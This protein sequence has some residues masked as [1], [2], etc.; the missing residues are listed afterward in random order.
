MKTDN[1]GL[2]TSL[3]Q[4]PDLEPQPLSWVVKPAPRAKSPAPLPSSGRLWAVL[5]LLV[6][7]G[8]HALALWIPFGQEQSLE[9][10]PDEEEAIALT[11]L[12]PS[13]PESAEAIPTPPP[14]APRATPPVPTARPQAP[15]PSRTIPAVASVTPVTNPVTPGR[16]E[17]AGA[18]PETDLFLTEFP[19][20]PG[21]KPGVLGL[22]DAYAAFSQNTEAALNPVAN[23]F[24]TELQAK[25]YTLQDLSEQAS[26]RVYLVS[27]GD[28]RQYLTLIS[29]PE[30]AGTNI[31]LS[32][33]EL[34]ED[35][36]SANIISQ[37]ELDFYSDL[38]I[39]TINNEEWQRLSEPSFLLAQP[40]AFVAEIDPENFVERL[41][42]GI[43]RA[44][45]ATQHPDS[46]ALFAELQT[47]F[48]VA[49]FTIE[50]SGNYGG[51]Q[52]YKITRD[53]VTGYLSLV[54]T[55]DGTGTAIFVW[56]RAPV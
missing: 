52:L 47:R 19:R 11:Q 44:L 32:P 41:R 35:L 42:P 28:T 30:G 3:E 16:S 9:E 33:K 10:A 21:A 24:E 39:P 54:P 14:E 26:R 37:E 56:N 31:L 51:G 2:E 55:Q 22:P 27:K 1:S 17:A 7:V 38:P 8:L 25:G 5:I 18:K 4:S 13:E 45:V 34:P 23:F 53:G 36:G 49:Y 29:N 15:Q 48:Q 50:P 43:Q 46:Q 20:Y 40:D 6:S 12:T